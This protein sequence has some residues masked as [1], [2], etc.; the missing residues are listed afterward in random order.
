[1]FVQ[2][3]LHYFLSWNAALSAVREEAYI[4]SFEV[5]LFSLVLLKNVTIAKFHLEENIVTVV[6]WQTPLL[7]M[8]LLKKINWL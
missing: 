3:I 7:V 1:M 5:K 6:I 8:L 4:P 2:V